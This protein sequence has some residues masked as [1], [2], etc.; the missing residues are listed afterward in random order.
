M[1]PIPASFRGV[2]L[3]GNKTCVLNT[4]DVADPGPNQVLVQVRASSLCGSDLRAIYRPSVHKTGPEGYTGVI[5]GHEPCGIVVKCGSEVST[6]WRIGVRVIIYHISGCGACRSCRKGLYISCSSETR[7]AY[8]WQRDGGHGEY[9]VADQ[10]SLVAL[11]QP[12]TYIDGSIVACGFGTAYAALLRAQV[13]GRD[14]VLVVGLG[15]VGLGVALLAQRLGAQKVLGIDI[16]QDRVLFA[17]NLGIEAMQHGEDDAA[18]VKEWLGASGLESDG[19]DV[20]IDCSGNSAARSTCLKAA[21]EWGRVGFVGEGGTV[22][23]DVSSDVIH[24][25]LSIFGSWVCSISQMEELVENLCAWNLHPECTVSHTFVLE[26]AAKAYEVFD[27]GKTGKCT[28]VYQGEQKEY[29]RP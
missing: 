4:Y 8:G 23:F 16:E 27:S 12:L 7:R 13:S 21:A 29:D 22:T 25:N 3:P 24:K 10:Q 1:S 14:S 17:T 20:A 15:P 5:A 9:L 28:I 19:V 18:L 2:V 26:E 6:K 11:P